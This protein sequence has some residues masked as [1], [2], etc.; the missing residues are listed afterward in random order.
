MLLRQMA[1]VMITH[2][3]RPFSQR[4]LKRREIYGDAWVLHVSDSGL[5]V[6]LRSL[7]YPGF[8]YSLEAGTSSG[9]GGSYFGLGDRNDDL[10]F[11]I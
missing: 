11:M 3:R 4:S 1:A 8:E 7:L 5:E 6:S 10:L 2:T 9:F